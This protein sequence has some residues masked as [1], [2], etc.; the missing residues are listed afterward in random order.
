MEPVSLDF[1]NRCTSVRGV[2]RSTEGDYNRREAHNRSPASVDVGYAARLRKRV[3][4]ISQRGKFY[5]SSNLIFAT[6]RALT[7]FAS[8]F[9]LPRKN[10]TDN[11]IHRF[12][13]TSILCN[14]S[15]VISEANTFL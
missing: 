11:K 7:S 8:L 5:L 2:L 4:G 10:Y 12:S 9:S 13:V 15:I 1:C 14:T 3:L 6:V